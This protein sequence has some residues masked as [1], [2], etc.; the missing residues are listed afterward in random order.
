MKRKT[1][2]ELRVFG[3]EKANI[4]VKFSLA[5][6]GENLRGESIIMKHHSL[7]HR[8]VCTRS[9]SRSQPDNVDTEINKH[10]RIHKLFHF[11]YVGNN[12][13]SKQRR[14]SQLWLMHGNSALSKEY[15]FQKNICSNSGAIHVHVK[16]I[17]RNEKNACLFSREIALVHP[18]SGF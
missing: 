9:R 6:L 11:G 17:R 12:Q 15:F 18:L 3:F 2:N 13:Q 4:N 1:V 16:C 14:H 7:V 10:K 8:T 5:S